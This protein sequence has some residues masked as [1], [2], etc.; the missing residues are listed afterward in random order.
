MTNK[1]LSI[2]SPVHLPT[3]NE[4][5]EIVDVRLKNIYG[6]YIGCE[7]VWDSIPEWSRKQKTETE[8]IKLQSRF[9]EMVRG[10]WITTNNKSHDS[11]LMLDKVPIFQPA[12]L[13]KE[14]F[15]CEVEKPD[16]TGTE[17]HT[18]YSP[19]ADGEYQAAQSQ[20]WFEGFEESKK[21]EI[22]FEVF[23][24]NYPIGIEFN[25]NKPVLVFG[26]KETMVREMFDVYDFIYHI[27]RYNRTASTP[28]KINFTENF[29]KALLQ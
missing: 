4:W 2:L 6:K 21:L 17:T 8:A 11:I 5:M 3:Q 24:P 18:N 19:E 9:E 16:F 7:Y 1:I 27:D 13:K 28:I 23:M 22:Q 12:L 15:V 14:M 25:K 10:K 20:I 26:R 29:V